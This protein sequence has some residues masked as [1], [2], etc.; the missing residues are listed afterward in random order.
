VFQELL[1]RE[2]A[3]YGVLTSEQCETLERHFDLL[4][5]WNPKLNLTRML[6]V[7]EAVKLHYCES[8]FLGTLLADTDRI[9]DIG[10]GAGFPG[11]PLAL[12]LPG[13]QVDLVE[14]HNRKAVFLNEASRLIRNVSVLAS[15]G[16]H[17]TGKYDWLVSRAVRPEE[18]LSLRLAPNVAILMS[19]DGVQN[20]KPQR[21]V[22]VPWGEDRVVAMF[23][24]KH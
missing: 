7:E 17:V 4:S 14:A 3:P 2:F 16:E 20:L 18:I 5:R 24:V 21:V 13:T 10:S 8:L 19:G 15:R 6:D 9:V 12:I 11:I 22:K 1:A 23:H